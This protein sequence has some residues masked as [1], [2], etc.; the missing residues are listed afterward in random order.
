MAIGT[1]VRCSLQIKSGYTPVV[2]GQIDS[3]E[4]PQLFVLT[5]R[6]RSWDTQR[7]F[8]LV[9]PSS[10]EATPTAAK[11]CGFCGAARLA[12]G[13]F[14]GSCGTRFSDNQPDT[15]IENTPFATKLLETA[16][17]I[18]LMQL[19]GSD[20][21][22]Q[23]SELSETILDAAKTGLA[24][25]K[26]DE[27]DRSHAERFIE[28]LERL[29][30]D[31]SLELEEII[32]GLSGEPHAL[33][34]LALAQ[35]IGQKVDASET[36]VAEEIDGLKVLLTEAPFTY[37]YWAPFKKVLKRIPPEHYPV[38]FAQAVARLTATGNAAGSEDREMRYESIQAIRRLGDVARPKTREYLRRQ[39]LREYRRLVSE[40]PEIFVLIATE[41]LLA[42]DSLRPA[43]DIILGFILN[44]N[45]EFR[46]KWSRRAIDFPQGQTFLSPAADGWDAHPE[47]LERLWTETTRQSEI[48]SFAFQGLRSRNILLPEISGKQLALAL[49][50]GYD[51]LM[52]YAASQVTHRPDSWEYLRDEWRIVV[53]SIDE[54][55]RRSVLH[56]HELPLQAIEFFLEL[57]DAE[58]SP[59]A[60]E[61]FIARFQEVEEGQ[62]RVTTP[63]WFQLLSAA[64]ADQLDILF[65]KV[66]SA[67]EGERFVPTHLSVAAD[68]LAEVVTSN[69]ETHPAIPT[70]AYLA[71]RVALTDGFTR[72]APEA[73]ARAIFV[74]SLYRKTLG[75]AWSSE[76]VDKMD[77]AVLAK[78]LV[79]MSTDGERAEKALPPE[80]LGGWAVASQ[81]LVHELA[82]QLGTKH[83]PEYLLNQ[84][85]REFGD[86]PGIVAGLWFVTALPTDENIRVALE[87]ARNIPDVTTAEIGRLCTEILKQSDASTLTAFRTTAAEE[88]WAEIDFGALISHSPEW[89]RALWRM[90]EDSET[91]EWLAEVFIA[92]IPATPFLHEL[93]PDDFRDPKPAQADVLKALLLQLSAKG[94]LSDEQ[95][96]LAA[97]SQN[98]E[99]SQLGIDILRHKGG[100]QAV[101]LPLVESELPLPVAAGFDALLGIKDKDAMTDAL[102]L[103]LDSAAEVVRKRALEMVDTLGDR[104]DREKLFLAL[105]E[106]THPDVVNRVAEEALVA[107]WATSPSV[108]S[109]D[110]KV[111]LVRRR[112]RKAKELVKKRLD[113]TTPGDYTPTPERVSILLDM[114]HHGKPRDAEWAHQR[115]A[116]LL[117]AGVAIEDVKVSVVNQEAHNG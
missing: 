7:V 44:G 22:Q 63:L 71:V 55:T 6:W 25:Q 65:E 15:T 87:R 93:L 98:G 54:S 112:T 36:L 80:M 75:A 92:S 61:V 29:L 91:E 38:E 103:A 18:H 64:N 83:N 14:C 97:T 85:W 79:F 53:N 84:V 115:L 45:G 114:A 9:A 66:F 58:L 116:Q 52:Q 46:D 21:S 69:W 3:P 77:L 48:Q 88:L 10:T 37:G 8:P 90:L 73:L 111:L 113:V 19:A 34:S 24:H 106:S 51:P 42:V 50:S 100:L 81:E 105:S 13:R 47:F 86:D 43:G 117:L 30:S 2:L 99:I 62:H 32:D 26:M 96:L 108:H 12:G 70:L 1:T 110:D 72:V 94:S 101:W 35:R 82:Q 57:S 11:F 74:M 28:N 41:Y 89:R 20:T 23:F 76:W 33:L 49:R 109:F 17:R 60:V 95:T 56:H 107:S 5:G 27:R 67:A 4:G 16:S 78:S 102:L 40:S 68:A 59:A 104:F 39:Q 31:Q